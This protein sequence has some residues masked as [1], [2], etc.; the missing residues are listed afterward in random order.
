MAFVVETEINS[1]SDNPLVNNKNEIISA[2]LFHAQAVGM[3]MDCAAIALTTLGAISERRISALVNGD[4]GLP[5]FLVEDSGLN[6][7][8]MIIH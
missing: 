2:G 7:G 1:V 3:A 5:P 6:S 4:F 8:F